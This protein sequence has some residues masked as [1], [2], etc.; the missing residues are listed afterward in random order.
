MPRKGQCVDLT[1]QRFGRLV[2][3]G[4]IEGAHSRRQ[5]ECRCD[6]GVTC[7]PLRNNLA[8]GHTTSCGCL[9]VE[10]QSSHSVT[11][12]AS[13]KGHHTREYRAWAG[14]RKRCFTTTDRKYPSYGGRGITMCERWRLDYANFRE[15]MG[16]CPDGL[17]LE[18]NDVN[19]NYEPLNCR[20]ATTLDQARN[21]RATKLSIESAREIRALRL[22]GGW[23]QKRLAV[24]FGVDPAMVARVL[25]GL[26]WK[27]AGTWTGP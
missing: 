19:G 7:R 23:T 13:R 8:R 9:K 24:K 5:W 14:A 12:G 18:R 11:H 21:K 20:W 2:V 16:L 15:D 25:N 1:G 27:E 3:V 22:A 10:M 26:A 4:R 17:T 6:C